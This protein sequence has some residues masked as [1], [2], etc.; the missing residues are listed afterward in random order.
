MNINQFQ[1]NYFLQ[2]EYQQ[3][4]EIEFYCRIIVKDKQNNQEITRIETRINA[5]DVEQNLTDSQF[6]ITPISWENYLNQSIIMLFNMLM[7][8]LNISDIHNVDGQDSITEFF[9]ENPFHNE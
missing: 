6:T 3:V 4:S 9:S 8:R 1:T 5:L 7:L 2:R